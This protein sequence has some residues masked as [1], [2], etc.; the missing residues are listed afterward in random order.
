[1]SLC[2]LRSRYEGTSR[3]MRRMLGLPYE[4]LTHTD[5]SH[6]RCTVRTEGPPAAA[7]AGALT[8]HPTL[9]SKAPAAPSSAPGLHLHAPPLSSASA[10]HVFVSCFAGER[11]CFLTSGSL[12]VWRPNGHCP[13]SSLGRMCHMLLVL[14]ILLSS[15]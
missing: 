15:Q 8:T 1:M 5:A 14:A 9:S 2:S 4:T 12:R 10:L 11:P 6:V 13:L 7:G 3:S